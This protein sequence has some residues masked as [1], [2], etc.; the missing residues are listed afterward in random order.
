MFKI[1][2]TGTGDGKPNVQIK[3][4]KRALWHNLWHAVGSPTYP[5]PSSSKKKKQQQMKSNAKGAE[6]N[7]FLHASFCIQAYIRPNKT[8]SALLSVVARLKIKK[9]SLCI[10]LLYECKH[11]LYIINYI[12]FSKVF[13]LN[14]IFLPSELNF[15]SKC[16][17]CQSLL[18]QILKKKKWNESTFWRFKSCRSGI[19]ET[20][21]TLHK[22]S[23]KNRRCEV[24]Q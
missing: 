1:K 20:I 19:A 13:R 10:L 17:I 22:W 6:T 8:S 18:I 9:R 21:Y 3:T 24:V 4:M 14:I 16:N 15:Q 5:P 11:F 2:S 23:I 7:M 12:I